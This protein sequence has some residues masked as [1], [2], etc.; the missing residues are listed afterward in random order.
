ME[1]VN[2]TAFSFACI[3][4]RLSFPNHSLTL[5]V[6][7][8]F[9]LSPG[10][11]AQPSP[12]QPFPTG[13]IFYPDDEEMQ[14][15]SRYESDYAYFKPRAD[16]LLVGKCYA[17][18]GVPVPL[19]R[20]AFQVGNKSKA[21]KI[22]GNRRWKRQ[23]FRWAITEPEPFKEM[24]LRYENS[25][26]GEKTGGNP[27]GK[28]DSAVKDE[29]GNE[30]WPLP[31]IEDPAN[32]VESPKSRPEP[33]G[34]GP[35]GRMWNA[36][37]AKMGS[38]TG[39]YTETRWPWFPEDFDW[40]H[41]NAAPEDMQLEGYL[42]GDEELFVENLH[43][44]HSQYGFRL[45][46]LRVRCFINRLAGS[47]TA[48]TVFVEVPMNLD[49]L[50]VDMEAEKV[51]LVWRGWTQALSEDHREVQDFFIL[52]EPLKQSPASIEECHRQF[53]TRQVE[54]DTALAV[55]S[56]EPVEIKMHAEETAASG[57]S[58]REKPAI[59]PTNLQ[60]KANALLSQMGIDLDSLPP[61]IREKQSRF[62]SNLAGANPEKVVELER[63]ELHTQMREAF[64]KLD[65]DPDHLPPLSSKAKAEQIRFMN[66]LGIKPAGVAADPELR[67]LWAMM[68]AV[69]PKMGIDLENL[70][71]LIE[72]ARKQQKRL[73]KQHGIEAEDTEATKERESIPLTRELI[74]ER[75]AR[76]DS[77]AG[78]DLH[79]LDLSGLELKGL[80]FSGANIS[81]ASL[82]AAHLQASILAGADMTGTDLSE[83]DLT[84]A[85]LADADLSRTKLEKAVL[86]D[87][88]LTG[89]TL[90]GS[91]LS[92]AVLTDAVFERA[93][94]AGAILDQVEATDA[95]FSQADLTEGSFHKSK[96][97]RADFSKAVLDRADFHG[98]DLREA[99]LDGAIGRKINLTEADL[100]EL[101][102]SEGCDFTEG[103]LWNAHGAGS[104]WDKANLTGSDFR[105]SQMEGAT[106]TGAC[107]K[108][109]DLSATDMRFSR[110]NKAK[111]QNAKL[112]QMNL[113]Q[114]SL[115]KADLSGADLSGSNM[116]GVEFLDAVIDG[117]HLNGTNLRMSKLQKM[118]MQA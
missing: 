62:I 71:P 29:W 17:P 90:I 69:M 34:F 39:N 26:G 101:R 53:L 15:N 86:K 84:G 112:V 63:Q 21:L 1:I 108:H 76:G 78:E 7:G 91:T 82:A 97:S 100:T 9:D 51:V 38:F 88:D 6:K 92:E 23:F 107:L 114:G 28:G 75:A 99:S 48:E 106:F 59:D 105:G 55:E 103:I 73:K 113:F 52:S 2:S 87:A 94:M 80:D 19:C 41:F 70:D 57:A 85:N 118:M 93:Q 18:N 36:R 24:E 43:P 11:V 95:N 16:L 77:F 104:I 81:S 66:A 68:G 64:A 47:D 3:A 20:A 30:I 79:G 44:V 14:G 74:R 102:A 25:F 111:L 72:Q 60:L 5:I 12:E 42:R 22:T 117:I 65:I 35:L 58:G 56:E 37:K 110:F 109:A 46:G 32:P 10:G 40:S 45:P 13:N 54:E 89:C 67:R 115:E 8:T 61:E 116:Y 50:W 31:N 4:G 27:I 98:A 96:C 49:T 33:V 83:T